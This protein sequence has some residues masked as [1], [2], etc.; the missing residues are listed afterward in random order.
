M[1]TK[2]N[3]NLISIRTGPL[4]WRVLR[5]YSR[6]PVLLWNYLTENALIPAKASKVRKVFFIPAGHGSPALV[7]KEYKITGIGALLR[8]WWLG[9]PASREWNALMHLS[10]AGIS[11]PKP[12]AVGCPAK[13]S[14]GTR[15]YL[16]MSHLTD[17]CNL[18]EILLEQKQSPLPRKELASSLGLLVRRMHDAGVLHNDLHAAN[19]LINSS[20][21]VY[22]MDLHGAS[23]HPHPSDRKKAADLVSLAGAFLIHG[24][25]TDRL[26]FYKAYAGEGA[27]RI[28]F[29]TAARRLEQGARDRLFVFLEKFDY[30]CLKPGRAFQALEVHELTG[31]AECSDRAHALASRLGPFP[32]EALVEDG[33]LMHRTRETAVY[34]LKND[35]ESYIVKVYKKTGFSGGAKRLLQGSKGRRA[36]F[37]YH[38]L[39]FRG[40]RVP[41]PVLFLEEPP[42]APTGRSFVVTE[43]QPDARTLDRFIAKADDPARAAV[44]K[45]LA[46]A[47]ARMHT[48]FLRNRDMKAQN[49]LVSRSGEIAFI[50]PDGITPMREPSLYFMARDLMRINASFEKGSGVSLADRVRFLKAYATQMRLGQGMFRE[51]W[52][53]ILHLT[54][55]KWDR[56]SRYKGRRR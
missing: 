42:H 31:M 45:R 20:G 50:D 7:L 6:L 30:R 21:L 41:K 46:E 35:G 9:A 48:L 15:T 28:R 32:L 18:E 23:L 54:W 4:G 13:L 34:L 3:D 2:N 36:W 19:L 47:V 8:A 26:R 33:L 38:R 5:K 49:I 25:R 43:F 29:K 52:R 17:G 53:E 22:I 1:N 40:I 37:N 27:D 11:V 55:T 10:S 14:F 51:L 39:F 12:L 44:G 24:S 56:W 16:A